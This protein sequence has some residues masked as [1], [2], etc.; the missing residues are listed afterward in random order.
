MRQ[1]WTALW[2]LIATLVGSAMPVANGLTEYASAFEASGR[3]ANKAMGNFEA[4]VDLDA[5]AAKL[6]LRKAEQDAATA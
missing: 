3:I 4:S 6:A 2:T 1:V 5:V